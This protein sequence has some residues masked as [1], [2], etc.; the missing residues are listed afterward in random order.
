[1]NRRGALQ[2]LCAGGLAAATY[3]LLRTR[4]A[5]AGNVGSRPRFYLQII[6]VGGMD[7]IYTMD[8]KRPTDLDKGFDVPYKPNTI[9]ETKAGRLGPQFKVLERWLPRVAIVNSFHQNSANHISGMAHITRMK[10]RMGN[11]TPSIMEILGSRRTT[12]ATATISMGSVYASAFSPTFLGEPGQII[13]GARPGLFKHLDDA[14][15]EDLAALGKALRREVKPLTAA[16]ATAQEKTTA[17][18]VLASAELVERVAK[19]PKFEPVKWAHPIEEEFAAGNDLQ[20]ALWMFEHG[21]TRCASIALGMY[22]SH[23]WNTTMQPP[24]CEYLAFLLDKVFEDLDRRIVDGKP[25]S[26]QTLVVVG[27]EIGRF[28]KLNAAHGKDH[29]PQVSQLFF[30]AAIKPGTDGATGRDMAALPIDLATGRPTKGGH[31][32]RLDDIGTALLHLDGAD[33]ELYGYVGERL[34]FLLEAA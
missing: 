30:G 8:P 21:L 1:M 5:R 26:Q 6:P 7:S 18:N 20:R 17:E 28:P 13:F 19:L 23:I 2:L 31:Q 11:G 3:P 4:A 16:R 24:L 10:T 25:M 27:S 12:E 9:V 33:P 15:P 14:D 29:F 32:L 34:P 22:D